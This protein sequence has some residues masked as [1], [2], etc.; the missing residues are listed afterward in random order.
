MENL[1]LYEN[2]GKEKVIVFTSR[3]QKEIRVTVEGSRIK[4]VENEANVRFPYQEGQMYNRSIEIWACNHYFK[5]NGKDPCGEK[6]IF[7][8][9]VS[10]IPKGHEFRLIY[11]NKFR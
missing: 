7:G 8:I 5:I 4:K 1:E 10:D 6:K 3:K 11:P 2:F 9:K